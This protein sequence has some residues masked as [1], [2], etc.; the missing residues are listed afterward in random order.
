[1][2]LGFVIALVSAPLLFGTAAHAE[3]HYDCTKPGNATKAACKTAPVAT[4][5]AMPTPPRA[6]AITTATSAER[7]YDCTKAGNAKKAAC[8]NVAAAPAPVVAKATAPM[9]P[10]PPPA[11]MAQPRPAPTPSP[12]P[13]ARAA[14]PAPVAG[15]PP[16][17][18]AWTEKNGKIVH[19]DCSK[20]G[21][22]TKQACKVP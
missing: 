15:G 21:N 10:K 19:Y 1:M 14:A 7:H 3:R 16:R 18:V 9:T 20:R 8:K 2:R 22:L 4:T 5:A 11:P 17:I 6:Q 13:V 12:A